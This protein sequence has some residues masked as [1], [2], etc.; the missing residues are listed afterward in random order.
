M[1]FHNFFKF[2]VTGKDLHK[3]GSYYNYVAVLMESTLNVT[4][5]VMYMCTHAY[6]LWSV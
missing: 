4:P 6:M 2:A 1:C 3:L 5:S